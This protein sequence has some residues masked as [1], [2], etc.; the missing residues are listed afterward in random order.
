MKRYFSAALLLSLAVQLQA[1]SEDKRYNIADYGAVAD[2]NT[3][4]LT[5]FLE[6]P[7]VIYIDAALFSF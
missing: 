2:G 5:G 1:A 7:H 3:L 6:S 4:N